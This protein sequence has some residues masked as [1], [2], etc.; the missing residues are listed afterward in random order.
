[1]KTK[2]PLD[3]RSFANDW[4]EIGHIY[5]KLLYWLYQREDAAKAR[6]YAERLERLLRK[7][8]PAHE[9]IL[10][11]ECR[12][13]VHEVKG[14]LRK[15]IEHRENEIR[16]I[17][18]LHA[19]IGDSPQKSVALKDYGHGDLADRLELLATLHHDGGDLEKALAALHESQR[20][21]HAH[22]IPFDG[23]DLLREYSKEKTRSQEEAIK[24]PAPAR[25]RSMA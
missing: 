7:A 14:D 4:D 24:L 19:A 1:M 23:E 5:D 10:G 13:L 2:P 15:A 17:R 25:K 9:S 22:K 16:L 11:E 21:C 20:L 12:S 8:D 18:Q 6:P 3:R